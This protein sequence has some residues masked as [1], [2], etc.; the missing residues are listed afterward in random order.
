MSA[1]CHDFA[2]VISKPLWV[3][4]GS[5]VLLILA[6]ILYIVYFLAK[7]EKTIDKTVFSEL[8]SF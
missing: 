2:L 8:I 6:K 3:K 1:I 4:L 5:I 7:I